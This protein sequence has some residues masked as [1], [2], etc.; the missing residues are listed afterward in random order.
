MHR[1]M[2]SPAPKNKYLP[3]KVAVAPSQLRLG[4]SVEPCGSPDARGRKLS[5]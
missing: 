5:G 2:S 4:E 3:R 1:R